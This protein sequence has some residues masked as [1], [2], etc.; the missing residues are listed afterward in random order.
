MGTSNPGGPFGRASE[1]DF[2]SHTDC[3]NPITTALV[4]LGYVQQPGRGIMRVK[5]ALER[6]GNPPFAVEVDGFTRITSRRRA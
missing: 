3:G 4:D 1:R 5:L 6:N 2:G